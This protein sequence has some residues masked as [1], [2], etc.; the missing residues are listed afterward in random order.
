MYLTLIC[1]CRKRKKL[2]QEHSLEKN[3]CDLIH[4]QSLFSLSYLIII[5]LIIP[6]KNLYVI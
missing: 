6:V 4:R 1:L 3:A 2:L 5:H